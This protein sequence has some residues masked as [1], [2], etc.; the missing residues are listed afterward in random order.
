MVDRRGIGSWL[1]G[2]SAASGVDHG[3][4]GLRLGLPAEG[5]GSVAGFGRRALALAVDWVLA[6]VIANGLL[7]GWG[8]PSLVPLLVLLVENV[9]LV[10]TAGYTV[11]H[12]LLGLRVTTLTGRP[13]GL[14]KALV[15]SLLLILAVPPLIWDRDQR[16]L[17]DKAAGTVLLRT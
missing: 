13:P 3:P 7:R 5:P 15:R 12:R 8:S 2:P 14:V 4:P 6:L 9:L 17:H 1:E 11:G 16:G 10:G